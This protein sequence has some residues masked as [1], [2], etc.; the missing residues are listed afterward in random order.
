MHR[1][2]YTHGPVEQS[3]WCLIYNIFTPAWTYIAPRI[4]IKIHQK[5]DNTFSLVTKHYFIETI[6]LNIFYLIV[7]EHSNICCS[8][9]QLADGPFKPQ[10]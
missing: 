2:A 10:F 6:F 3:K 4:R 5:T 9:G 1:S 7:H 8:F